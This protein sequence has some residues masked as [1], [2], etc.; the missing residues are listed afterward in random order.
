MAKSKKSQH[1]KG[2]SANTSGAKPL[3]SNRKQSVLKRKP[4]MS[5]LSQPLGKAGKTK[6]LAKIIVPI[7][8]VKGAPRKV[9]GTADNFLGLEPKASAYETSGVVVISAPY[10]KTVSYGGGT[11]KAPE[12][13]IDAS[14]Y[15]EF[16]DD[17]FFRE[18]C[19]ETGI[20]TLPPLDFGNKTG[21]EMLSQLES[22][23]KKEIKAGKFVVT[24]GGEHTISTAPIA[25]HFAKYPKMAVLHFDAHS[26]LRDEY[27]GTPYSHACFMHRVADAGFPMQ[28]LVQV[29]IR[30]QS[31]DEWRFAKQNKVRTFYATAIRRKEHGRKWQ[32]AVVEA[33]GDAEEIYVTFDVDYFDPS[34]MPTTGTPEPDGFMWDETMEIFR[35][36][37]KSGKRIVGF[38]V[39]EL[40]PN[41]QQQHATYLAAKLV[42]RLLNF[43]LVRLK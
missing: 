5:K 6:S 24:L 22:A 9:L 14:Q 8:E 12:A 16:F 13:I 4:I 35:R 3:P 1:A 15:V 31:I 36:L 20:A 7:V 26:D 39:V 34:I 40:S 30:A 21:Q 42:Y 32:K 28:R 29:G 23:V 25:A 10:E 33:L 43:A 18:V 41:K 27:S 38:D 11:A 37:R 19:F 17:E 2:A